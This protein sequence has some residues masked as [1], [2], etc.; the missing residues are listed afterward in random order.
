MADMNGSTIITL[1]NY[2]S[3]AVMF[4]CCIL[5]STQSNS[6]MQRLALLLSM[7]VTLCSVGFIIR[8]E[9]TDTSTYMAGQRICYGFV[10]HAMFLLFLFVLEY[11][12]Y[13]I[14]KFVQYL[15]HGINFLI[16]F[17]VLTLNHHRLFYI[18]YHGI[19]ENGQFDVEK[20]YGFV[21]TVELALIAIY[22]VSYFV[23]SIIFTVKN[24]RNRRNYV[25]RLLIVSLIPCVAYIVPKLMGRANDIQNIAFAAFF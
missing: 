3:L 16:T 15:F 4:A 13:S 25:W 8:I 23:V 5:I 22:I 19:M 9:A 11:C 12:R 21:H 1:L 2:A 10:T 24:I 7:V 14:P 18:S 6:R 20:E 17:V